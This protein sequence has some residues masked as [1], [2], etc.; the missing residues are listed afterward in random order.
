MECDNSHKINSAVDENLMAEAPSLRSIS[1]PHPSFPVS[2][3]VRYLFWYDDNLFKCESLI[4][5]QRF[6]YEFCTKFQIQ[7][8]VIIFFFK[9]KI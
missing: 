8:H 1:L 3:G 9:Y 2:I 4:L 6:V 5:N 7:F